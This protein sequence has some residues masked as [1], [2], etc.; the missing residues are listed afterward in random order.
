MEVL[1]SLLAVWHLLCVLFERPD[2]RNFPTVQQRREEF[3]KSQQRH[4]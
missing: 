4:K 3:I 2:P 1:F